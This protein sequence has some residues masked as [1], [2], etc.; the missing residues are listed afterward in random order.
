M[1]SL[2]ILSVLTLA[3][4]ASEARATEICGNGVDDDA[5]SL[6]DEG[7]M[8]S[9]TTG[10]CESPLDCGDTGAVSPKTGAL[11]Y[12]L[13]SDLAI[14][15]PYGPRLTFNRFYT[16]Q[17]DPAGGGFNVPAYRRPLGDRWQHQYMSWL[18]L[19]TS[20]SPD[21]VVLHTT[22][23]QEILFKYDSTASGYDYYLPQAGFHFKHLRQ[24][25]SSPYKWELKT[26]TGEVFVYDWSSPTGKLIEIWDTLATPNKLVLTYDGNG[27]VSTVTDASGKR[28]LTFSYSS[29][30][31]AT[32]IY[33][34]DSGGQGWIDSVTIAFT[35]TNGNLTKLQRNSITVDDYVYTAGN[36]L[37]EILGPDGL[38][39]KIK[40][41]AATPGQVVLTT[42]AGATVGYEFNSA[43]AA[44][45][46]ETAVYFNA[47]TTACDDD[48]D[49]ASGMMCGGETD[50]TSSNTGVC[51][52]AGRCLTV[53]SPNEDIVTLVAPLAPTSHTC[54]GACTDVA[55]Y[56]WDTASGTKAD[57][58][59]VQD[60]EGHWVSY[61]YD[62]N[63]M[64]TIMAVGDT[65]NDPTNSSSGIQS[66]MYYGNSSFPGRVTEVRRASD[67][68]SGTCSQSVSTDCK[69]T[70]YTYNSDG[71]IGSVQ[72]LGFTLD[73]S[74]AWV[75]Y[76]YTTSYTYDSKGRLTQID[77]PLSG[78]NDVTNYAYYSSSDNLLNGFL[79]TTQRKK[80][81]SNYLTTEQKTYDIWGKSTST[82]QPD[83]TL[84]C[85]THDANH[86]FLTVLR[87]TMSTQT[88]CTT[89]SA[90]IVTTYARD[91]WGRVTQVTK[92]TADCVHYDYDTS[93]RLSTIVRSDN[94][95]SYGDTVTYTYLDGDLISK[96]E[97]TDVSSTVVRRQEYTYW[98]S[99]RLKTIK[100]PV[101]TQSGT[102]TYDDRGLVVTYEAPSSLGKTGSDYDAQGR[103]TERRLYLDATN[104][105]AWDMAYASL[106]LPTSITDEDSKSIAPTYDDLGRRVRLVSPDSG[107]T[108]YLY[109]A[110]SRVSTRIEADGTAGEQSHSFTYDNVDRIL[111]EDYHG[112]CGTG[113]GAEVQYV[114]DA[115]PVTCPT[116]GGG[117]DCLYTAARLAYVKSIMYCDTGKADKTYDQE[118]FFSYDRAGRLDIDYMQDDGGRIAKVPYSYTKDGTQKSTMAPSGFKLVWGFNGTG[119]ADADR[120]KSLSISG[121]V[122]ATDVVDTVTWQPFGG[123]KSYNHKN[124]VN[125]H[126]LSTKLTYDLAYRVTDVLVEESTGPDVF[127]AAIARDDKGRVTARDYTGGHASMQDSYLLYDWQDRI[128]CERTTSGSTCPTS[129]STLKN[130][131]NGSPPYTAS[132]DRDDFLHAIVG[133]ANYTHEVAL[134]SGK[135]QLDYVNQSGTGGLGYT[136]FTWDSRGNR[137]YEDNSGQ[138]HDRRDYTYDS[139]GNLLT[140][141]GDYR[142]SGSWHAYTVTNAYDHKSRRIYKAFVDTTNSKVSEWFFYY[143]ATDRLTEVLYYPDVSDQDTFSLYNL[144]WLGNRL[145]YYHQID[146]APHSAV[147]S[148]RYVHTD[149]TGRPVE[150]YSWP[151]SGDGARVWAIDPD[152]WG[153]D[154]VVLGSTV[155]QPVVLAG[156]YRDVETAALRDDLNPFK[157]ALALRLGR[158]F[159]P[160]VATRLQSTGPGGVSGY[161]GSV[162]YADLGG[163][164]SYGTQSMTFGFGFVGG[165]F[166][167]WGE[168]RL[169]EGSGGFGWTDPWTSCADRPNSERPEH[170]CGFGGGEVEWLPGLCTEAIQW[171]PSYLAIALCEIAA[172]H[173]HQNPDEKNQEWI[174]FCDCLIPPWSWT[175]R[176]TCAKLTFR[177][178][179]KKLLFCEEVLTGN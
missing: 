17:Y 148:R 96:V 103:E 121:S 61:D 100:D 18:T 87:E 110:A 5:N 144:G 51:F 166:T 156:Q 97:I 62:S 44:C 74:A 72:E 91:V 20:A 75:S 19:N 128:T 164:D 163:G 152:A 102:L 11:K 135:D 69:R 15:V 21:E 158:A 4:L 16:S 132:N 40:Y 120:V 99:R 52:Y 90:D 83:G 136:Y 150:M 111:A 31:V 55:E 127:R 60:P 176:T 80:D 78:S 153:N 167:V 117:A 114:Y 88:T 143:D 122:S 146:Y 165:N 22:E 34:Y 123:I 171:E 154:N 2:A 39:K 118:T 59:G 9:E 179:D 6:V 79:Q 137:S 85:R 105:D 160:W 115:P 109:D 70:L 33:A 38:S 162:G 46:G 82:L 89:H 130:N 58:I 125:A 94:C 155:F 27:Q 65:D 23:G 28:R 10:V 57:L 106:R 1:R 101:S 126:V 25:T 71:L 81:S 53:D 175:I 139:R 151:T 131:I 24:A 170:G 108:L 104:N 35:Y 142:Y 112:S 178:L 7:C 177:P 8:P 86:G 49:C 134:T 141:S 133:N 159:D 3:A 43:R 14:N 172:A 161:A 42:L 107:T 168:G 93:G 140:V 45:S 173:A 138:S 48:A 119:A 169:M 68:G 113:A 64:P 147:T 84:T 95:Q 29:S 129:G 92:P 30:K 67:K 149:E 47:S 41:A 36:Y 32:I 12:E 124:K 54:E 26:L 63:G 116:G 73:S 13:P 37:T 98:E 76:D 157:P 145:V 174:D 77:G 50:P 56:A 66:W